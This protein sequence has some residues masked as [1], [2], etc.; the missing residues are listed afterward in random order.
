M[1]RSLK[2]THG[3]TQ[4]WKM[5]PKGN[6]AICDGKRSSDWMSF[7]F[8]DE[9]C[10]LVSSSRAPLQ[11]RGVWIRRGFE[12]NQRGWDFLLG[13]TLKAFFFGWGIRR[14][15]FL[16]CVF[17]S[18]C[19]FF[20]GTLVETF[21]RAFHR[22]H[23]SFPL[24]LLLRLLIPIFLSIAGSFMKNLKSKVLVKWNWND[25]PIDV[26]AIYFPWFSSEYCDAAV[27]S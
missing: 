5:S 22:I 12:R 7:F 9:D 27:V 3:S 11:T 13:M 4:N 23:G 24:F 1:Y 10:K 17:L 19:C 15:G 25:V 16:F 21:T 6:R 20:C 2:R 8:T 14:V 18:F 26:S